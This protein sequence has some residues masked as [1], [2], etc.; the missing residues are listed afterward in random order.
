MIHPK[1]GNAPLTSAAM[2]DGDGPT[3]VALSP[4]LVFKKQ[5]N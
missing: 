3:L 2:L 4:S 1:A 5:E